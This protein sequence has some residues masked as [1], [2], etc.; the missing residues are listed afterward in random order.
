M[1]RR[2]DIDNAIWGD[3]EFEALSP[4]A[5]LLY[6][7]SFTNSQC[8]MAGVYKVSV[9]RMA[10]ETGL[11]TAR[12]EKALAQLVEQAFLVY[13]AP[14]LWVRS[15]VKHIRSESPSMARSIAKDVKALDDEVP[16]RR[17][18]LD[19]YGAVSWLRDALAELGSSKPKTDTL[20]TPS[21][22]PLQGV[23]GNGK[24]KGTNNSDGD[25][26]RPDVDRLCSLLA[27][28]VVENGR[29]SHLVDPGS[30]GW[31]DAA[32]LLLDRDK[33]PVGE[34]ERLI[35]WCQAD[36]FWRSNILSM[37]KF[38]EKYDQLRLKAGPALRPVVAVVDRTD[39][40]LAEARR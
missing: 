23:Q 19:R 6:L 35:R 16:I 21:P 12:T 39:D 15:R 38:R 36:E 29:P 28:L 30:A 27:S 9:A 37:P 5:K 17:Q 11:N 31:R 2:E 18:F 14:W 3:P 24:G 1:G 13:E 20:S 4:D 22:D 7:W 10:G 26:P 8:N 40:R 33:R 25:L 32:R 34:A